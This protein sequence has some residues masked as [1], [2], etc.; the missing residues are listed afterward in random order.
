MRQ[1]H[2]IFQVL[3]LEKAVELAIIVL[4][5]YMIPHVN[6]NE[7]LYVSV[8]HICDFDNKA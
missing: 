5:S 4:D 2:P 6:A 7:L 1:M 8:F 3:P